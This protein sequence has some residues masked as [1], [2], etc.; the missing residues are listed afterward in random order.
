MTLSAL[1]AA[2]EA[3]LE[4]EDWPTDAAFGESGRELIGDLAQAATD[5]QRDFTETSP[6]SSQHRSSVQPR[7]SPHPGIPEGAPAV[8]EEVKEYPSWICRPCG[9]KYGRGLP[10]G[11]T[12]TFHGG[13]CDV[14]GHAGAVT[15]PRDYGHL[16]P[17]WKDERKP[18]R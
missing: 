7:R 4:M 6:G 17:E 3:Y 12:C 15:Q 14:C 5:Y 8:P 16:R 2:R 11:H 13:T 1:E 18:K 9:L 10:A